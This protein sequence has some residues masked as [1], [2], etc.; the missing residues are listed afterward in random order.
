M[1]RL[2]T[3]IEGL[4][5][6]RFVLVIGTAGGVLQGIPRFFLGSA[7][8]TG[9]HVGQF[10]LVVVTSVLWWMAAAI[11]WWIAVRRRR[12]SV[13]IT[14][15][16]LTIGLALANVLD[17]ALAA[18]VASIETKGRYAELVFHALGTF[19]SSNLLLILV[20]SVS[21]FLGSAMLVGLGRHLAGGERLTTPTPP[22]SS[23][24]EALT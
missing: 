13:W 12:Y 16:H 3:H 2:A 24:P 6:A 9:A 8:S 19:A 1:R 23:H 11:V 20:R 15:A 22:P 5:P 18:V 7:A 17:M 10:V 4:S 21:W 14:A